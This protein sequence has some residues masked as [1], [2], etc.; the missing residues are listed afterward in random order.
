M[1][2]AVWPKRAEGTESTTQRQHSRA[3]SSPDPE[4]CDSSTANTDQKDPL[5]Q[6]DDSADEA[7]LERQRRGDAQPQL[8][9]MDMMRVMKRPVPVTRTLVMPGTRV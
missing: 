4:D 7:E 8:V 9:P 5:A 1:P 2:Q 6:E 3:N